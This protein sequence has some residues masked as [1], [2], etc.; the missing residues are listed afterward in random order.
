[1]KTVDPKE[2]SLLISEAADLIDRVSEAIRK[3]QAFYVGQQQEDGYWWY[4]LESNVTI[5]SE[6]LMLLHFLGSKD[7]ERD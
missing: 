4:E 6:Y 2:K 1:M 3:T 7:R 5:T